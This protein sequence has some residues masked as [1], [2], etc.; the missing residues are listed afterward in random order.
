MVLL[1]TYDADADGYPAPTFA[2]TTA[3]AGMT[4]D[5]AGGYGI[6]DSGRCW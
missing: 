1:Y 3:P 6:L 4:I 2:L 5:A